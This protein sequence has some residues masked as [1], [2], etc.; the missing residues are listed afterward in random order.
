[1]LNIALISQ[2][3]LGLTEHC[4]FDINIMFDWDIIFEKSMKKEIL[5][6]FIFQLL[7]YSPIDFENKIQIV[8]IKG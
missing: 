5:N 4:V 2:H 1:M 6:I 7:Q 3:F 8:R